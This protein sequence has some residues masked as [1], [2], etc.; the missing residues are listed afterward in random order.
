MKNVE[1]EKDRE[2]GTRSKMWNNDG[3][4]EGVSSIQISIDWITVEESYYNWL[5]GKVDGRTLPKTKMQLAKEI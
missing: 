3:P 4:T 2:N 5:G 1:K